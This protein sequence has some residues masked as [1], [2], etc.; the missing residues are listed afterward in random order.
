MLRNLRKIFNI[1]TAMR[2]NQ[3]NANS[4][5]PSIIKSEQEA[6]AVQPE[7]DP[8]D[9]LVTGSSETKPIE[10]EEMDIVDPVAVPISPVSIRNINNTGDDTIVSGSGRTDSLGAHGQNGNHMTTG[11]LTNSPKRRRSSESQTGNPNQTTASSPR[12]EKRSLTPI[13]HIPNP[14]SES[15]GMHFK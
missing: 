12:G 8:T 3:I 9:R 11:S 1:N 2:N 15:P 6:Q 13:E 10:N 7:S 5:R 14:A 4:F